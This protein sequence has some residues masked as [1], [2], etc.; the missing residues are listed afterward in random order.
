MCPACG[1]D[2]FHALRRQRQWLTVFFVPV[3]P[4]GRAQGL[5]RCNLCGQ[6]TAEG[7]DHTTAVGVEAATKKCPEC[8]ELIKLEARLCRYCRRRFSEEENAA[9]RQMALAQVEE[10]QEQLKLRQL[11]RRA[12]VYSTLGWLLALPG[13]L[14]SILIGVG[15]VLSVTK[16]GL[17]PGRVVMA[18]ALWLLLSLPLWIGIL[19][20]RKSRS[21]LE[22]L[23]D[24]MKR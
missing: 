5:R 22:H 1:K 15:L 20:R 19:L 14:W 24:L 3:L 17:L 8:A 7:P 18:V 13:S 9:A 11:Q 4:L 10:A 23:E 2:T 12:R 16:E 6:E 21:I